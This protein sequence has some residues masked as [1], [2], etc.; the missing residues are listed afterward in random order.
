MLYAPA[1]PRLRD[2]TALLPCLA[3]LSLFSLAPVFVVNAW[4]LA[5]AP[6][7]AILLWRR[8]LPPRWVWAPAGLVGLAALAAPSP[9]LAVGFLWF[10]GFLVLTV[11][12]FQGLPSG[13]VIDALILGGVVHAILGPVDWMDGRLVGLLGN[14]NLAGSLLAICLA[15]AV[16][17]RRWLFAGIIGAGLLATKSV[18]SLLGLETGIVC[19]ALTSQ[20]GQQLIR[21]RPWL[22]ALLALVTLAGLLVTRGDRLYWSSL[23]PLQWATGIGM[24]HHAPLLG[25]GPGSFAAVWPNVYGVPTQQ[26]THAHSFYIQALAEAGIAGL[27]GIAPLAVGI[28]RHVRGPALAGLIVLGVHGLVDATAVH[29]VIAWLAAALVGIGSPRRNPAISRGEGAALLLA[30]LSPLAAWFVRLHY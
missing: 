19:L 29:P 30:V 7:L 16:A 28:V 18:G 22:L 27:L 13:Q 15:L 21:R 14:A 11:G 5:A 8:V 1:L 12:A 6:A 3:L 9:A 26:F 20:R 4:P 2:N 10:L 25:M 24:A 17:R 23:R